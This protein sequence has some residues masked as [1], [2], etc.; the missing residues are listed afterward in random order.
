MQLAYVH[1][2]NSSHRSFNHLTSQLPAHDAITVNYD[3]HQPLDASIA[4]VLK[5]L[6]KKPFVLIGHSLGGVISTLIALQKPE[7]VQKL[8]TISSPL[9]GSR[10]AGALKWIPG[11][12]KV[13]SDI[14][15][16]SK[17]ILAVESG[18]IDI[19]TLSI[20]STGGHL[21]TSGE[22]NDSVVT[23]SSQR[24]LKFGKKVEVKANHFEVLMHEKTIK[25][26]RD[27]LFS[28]EE[29]A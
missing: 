27:F 16:S 13:L 3:S 21:A 10:A 17:L 4:Q 11:Y 24:A 25:H 5:Q 23:V 19:P 14:T 7:L 9:A 26:V 22:A 29:H 6:P 2:F 28:D 1:G 18:K 20:I 15:P 12:P 8:I